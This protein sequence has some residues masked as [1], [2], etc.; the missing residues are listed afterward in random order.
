MN[1]DEVAPVNTG[2]LVAA[3]VYP[4]PDLFIERPLNEATPLTAATVA[5]PESIPL[6]GL[7]PMANVTFLVSVV[8]VLLFASVMRTVIAGV[9]ATAA[10]ALDGC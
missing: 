9:M 10:V 4:V 7:V 8:I 6:P 1:A 2:V 5:V 3:K